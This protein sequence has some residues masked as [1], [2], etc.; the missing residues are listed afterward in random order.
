MET[1]GFLDEFAESGENFFLAFGL[2]RP[3]V[4]FVAPK[5][6][7]IYMTWPIF[8]FLKVQMTI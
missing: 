4:P 7:L 2:Y 8:K 5:S 6:I 3:H 1:M